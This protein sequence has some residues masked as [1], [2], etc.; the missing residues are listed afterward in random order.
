MEA[1][2]GSTLAVFYRVL[3]HALAHEVGHI[4]WRSTAHEGSGLMKAV[5]SKA[6]WQRASVTII[7]FTPQQAR[8]IAERLA[9]VAAPVDFDV[10]SHLL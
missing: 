4:L 6:D 10:A 3:G 8:R 5:W 2:S 9:K 1:V 7:P